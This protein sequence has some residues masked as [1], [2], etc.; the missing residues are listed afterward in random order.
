MAFKP[1]AEIFRFSGFACCAGCACCFFCAAHLAR[2]AA[3]ILARPGLPIVRR[4][5]GAAGAVPVTDADAVAVTFGRPGP[6][7]PSCLVK[8]NPDDPLGLISETEAQL[9]QKK[10]AF[11]NTRRPN[12][13]L[14]ARDVLG[15]ACLRQV[16]SV[17]VRSR[18][19]C[20]KTRSQ[21]KCSGTPVCQGRQSQETTPCWR[22]PSL[23]IRANW[24]GSQRRSRRGG[25]D[26]YNPR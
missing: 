4:F 23:A 14:V 5:A 17:R 9:R 7:C 24:A 11:K 1:A 16:T 8:N 19:G 15:G 20:S 18:P 10:P 22:W 3:A 2:C 21:F 13:E 6:R 25:L 12:P 26:L